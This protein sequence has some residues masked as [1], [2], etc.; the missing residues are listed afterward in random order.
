MKYKKTLS[1]SDSYI[2]E[3]LKFATKGKQNS[4]DSDSSNTSDNR[5]IPSSQE[6]LK[7]EVLG[8]KKN[9]EIPTNNT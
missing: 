5:V 4:Q 9:D 8:V 3:R 2:S 7:L 1:E 6:L